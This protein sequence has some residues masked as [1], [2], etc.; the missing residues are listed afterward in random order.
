[1]ANKKI[2]SELKRIPLQITIQKNIIEELKFFAKEKDKAVSRIV[3]NAIIKE[4]NINQ[5]NKEL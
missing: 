2:S 4:L 1:M 3:E 5:I